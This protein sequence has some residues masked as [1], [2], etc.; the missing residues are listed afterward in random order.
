MLHCG[1]RYDLLVLLYGSI[2][3]AGLQYAI[4]GNRYGDMTCCSRERVSVKHVSL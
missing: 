4:R 2:F 3:Q 1:V